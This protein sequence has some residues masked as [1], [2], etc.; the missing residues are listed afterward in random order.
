MLRLTSGTFMV[1]YR[2]F[3]S[4]ICYLSG[5]ITQGYGSKA[6]SAFPPMKDSVETAM[7]QMAE[8]IGPLPISPVIQ[9]SF[10]RIWNRIRDDDALRI[11]T[12]ETLMKE[13]SNQIIQDLRLNLFLVISAERARFYEPEEPFFGEQVDRVFPSAS[14]DIAAAGLGLAY[15]EWTAAIFHMMRATEVALK[16]LA[17]GLGVKNVVVKEWQ[18]L[19]ADI[20]T[21]IQQKYQQ[22]KTARRDRSIQF[23]AE[24]R[25]SIA[26]FK[27]AWRNHVMHRREAHYDERDATRVWANA[28]AL[29]QQ[30][31]EKRP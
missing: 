2:D 20:D 24:A 13:L 12:A 29:I 17:K 8:E 27:D 5:G 22:P 16:K 26:G 3:T 11:D 28:G 30:L 18:T 15:E 14:A 31:A 4:A 7:K 6:V 21:A 9:D 23:Y 10:V 19:L 25:V 1:A